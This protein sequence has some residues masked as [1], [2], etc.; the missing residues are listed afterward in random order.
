MESW[1]QQVAEADAAQ[2][3]EGLDDGLAGRKDQ[4]VLDERR[5]RI[6][7][8]ERHGEFGRDDGADED[9]LPGTHGQRQDVAG[10]IERQGLAEAFEFVLADEVV[11]GP[12]SVNQAFVADVQRDVLVRVQSE[13]AE[14]IGNAGNQAGVELVNARRVPSTRRRYQYVSSARICG[15]RRYRGEPSSLRA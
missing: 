8:L 12:D 5:I 4:R 3:A 10:V 15:S 7:I 2:L 6:G 11:I 1:W 13:G 9:R 14:P